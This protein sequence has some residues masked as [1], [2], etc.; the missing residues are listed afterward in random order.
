M[1]ILDVYWGENLV[2]AFSRAGR[3]EYAFKY[4]DQ[5]IEK[6]DAKPI[7]LSLPKTSETY[8]EVAEYFF[9]NFLPEGFYRERICTALG[10]GSIDDFGLLSKIGAECAGA[11]SLIQHG[12]KVEE[13]G[14][15]SLININNIVETN[16]DISNIILFEGDD[17]HFSL[18][19]AQDKVAVKYDGVNLYRPIGTAPSTHIVKPQNK[20]FNNTV[21]LEFFAMKLGDMCGL[22]VPQVE[23]KYIKDQPLYI[24][25]RYDRVILQDGTVAKIHQE[26]FCQALGVDKLNKYQKDG[27]PSLSTCFSVLNRCAV[28]HAA[29][30][31]FLKM[32]A[33]NVCTGNVDFHGKNFSILY[34][35]E[36][37]SLSPCY[38]LVPVT[39]YP[40]CKNT[41]MSMDIGGAFDINSIT[42][43]NIKAL[44]DTVNIN[45][46]TVSDIFEDVCSNIIDK[47]PQ[48]LK[49]CK[50]IIKSKSALKDT[51]RATF[52]S[53]KR[54]TQIAHCLGKG[55]A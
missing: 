19:G 24:V 50:S 46:R 43:K 35:G 30:S 6:E 16:V 13:S 32:V 25:S 22:N 54:A 38:D 5:W 49:I 15:Y 14:Y 40:K 1:N 44:A 33:F 31:E 7:S 28:P 9:F 11:I 4:S 37:P 53:T 39:I 41:K 12:Q 17:L 55:G 10:L 29:K 51:G 52:E 36:K 23:I 34:S 20:I 18:A 27:G 42:V 48:C 26:D 21:E 3:N 47:A 2:G 45:R 8:D